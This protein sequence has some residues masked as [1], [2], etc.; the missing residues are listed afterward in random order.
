MASWRDHHPHRSPHARLLAT[1]LD[2]AHVHYTSANYYDP[3]K[4]Q[5]TDF[6]PFWEFVSGPLQAAGAG[7]PRPPDDTF[8]LQVVYE[9]WAGTASASPYLGAPFFGEVTID[10]RTGALTVALKDLENITHFT[11]TLDPGPA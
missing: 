7:G 1:G 11:Q 10:A 2:Q 5:F 3:A 8:G 6:D 4:A 9:R